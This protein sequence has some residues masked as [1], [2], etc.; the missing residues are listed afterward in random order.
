MYEWEDNVVSIHTRG[1][2]GSQVVLEL[3]TQ[4]GARCD[5]RRNREEERK[6]KKGVSW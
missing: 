2:G 3:D 6:G 1:K 5:N 4:T